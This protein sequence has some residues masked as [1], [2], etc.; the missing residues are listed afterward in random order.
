MK[1]IQFRGS[2][3]GFECRGWYFILSSLLHSSDLYILRG[4]S[5]LVRAMCTALEKDENEPETFYPGIYAIHRQ[6]DDFADHVEA[7]CKVYFDNLAAAKAAKKA[8]NS[9]T[10]EE[11]LKALREHPELIPQVMQILTQGKQEPHPAG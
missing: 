9:M 4:I 10:D 1:N 7:D 2:V 5:Q 11:F 3:T 6:L 8:D